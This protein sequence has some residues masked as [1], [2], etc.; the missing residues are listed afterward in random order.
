MI[1]FVICEDEDILASKYINVIDKF[2]MRND[3]EYKIHRFK[4]YT[5]DWEKFVTTNTEFKIHLLDIRTSAGSGIDA[6][7]RIREEFDDWV[8]MIIIITAYSEYKYE[9]LGKRLM[10]VDF[11]NKLDR[12]ESKLR[13]SL[14]ICIKHYNN[15]H[16]VLR[17][18]YKNTAYSIE[19]RHILYIERE[20]ES[21]V[22]KIVTI[23]GT[24]PIQGT[25]KSVLKNLDSRFFKSCRGT[26]VNSAMGIK[27]FFK[28]DNKKEVVRY[29]R[30]LR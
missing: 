7:R 13:E 2:M 27:D 17:Y 30:G 22:C 12:C 24:Y 10:L 3:A 16:K 8:S 28:Q 18:T 9:A 4:G 26:I 20:P 29:V 21:K 6:A 19:L 15:R 23:Y 5:K 1:N 25:I 14:L 11:I